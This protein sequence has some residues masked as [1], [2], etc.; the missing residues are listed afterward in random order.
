[1]TTLERCQLAKERGY[2]YCSVSGELKGVRGNV[3]IAKSVNGY[4]YVRLTIEGK[5]YNILGHRLAWF[6][7]YGTLPTNSIDHI[8]GNKSNNKIENLRDVT[9][10]EN[11]WNRTTAK[12]YVWKKN[13]NKFE[14]Q[15]SINGKTKF[16]GSFQTE[17]EARNSY[18][19]AKEIYHVINA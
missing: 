17:Q 7:Y 14:S 15:I 19:K 10:Q 3:M 6:L 11:Q 9:A 12:G 13:R 16:L 5:G 1:M 2:T 4:S 8:D 18:L